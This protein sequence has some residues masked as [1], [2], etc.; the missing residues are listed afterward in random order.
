MSYL[1][2]MQCQGVRDS[3]IFTQGIGRGKFGCPLGMAL[4]ADEQ[5]LLVVDYGVFEDRQSTRVNSHHWILGHYMGPRRGASIV[6]IRE[7]DGSWVRRLRG[8][9]DTLWEPRDV[10]VVPS[11]RNVVVND[12]RTDSVTVFASHDDDTVVQELRLGMSVNFFFFS[13]FS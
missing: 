7:A 12:L 2:V 9:R 11:T 10:A 8:P 3:S 1:C 13:F 6:V 5:F 4:T